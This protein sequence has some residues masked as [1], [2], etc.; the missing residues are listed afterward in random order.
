VLSRIDE[1]LPRHNISNIV[2]MLQSLA[3]I[4]LGLLSSIHAISL[5]LPNQLINS[6]VKAESKV[7]AGGLDGSKLW[8][9]A[10]ETSYDW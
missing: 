5:T 1:H 3:V 6:P 8:P 4:A 7:H 2:I 10:N 9:G